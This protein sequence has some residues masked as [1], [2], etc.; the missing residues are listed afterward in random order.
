MIGSR[1]TSHGRLKI[2]GRFRNSIPSGTS[3]QSRGQ[4]ADIMTS[5]ALEMTSNGSSSV[6]SQPAQSSSSKIKVNA[7]PEP[8]L[9]SRKEIDVLYEILD[10][11]RKA[12]DLLN[13]D[14]IVTGGSLLGA[15]RQH[16]ILF[17]DDDI[18]IAILDPNYGT[19]ESV[20]ET[21]ILPNLQSA[22]NQV[23]ES[24]TASNESK[25][26]YVYQ[27]KP[28]EGGDRI[29][30]KR[31]NNVFLDLFVLR[32]Y[33]TLESFVSVIGT[34]KNGQAQPESYVNG[35]LE[36]IQT[37]V[38]KTRPGDAPKEDSVFPF[39]QFATRK[40]IELWPK[41]V[42]LS[43]SSTTTSENKHDELFPLQRNLKFGPLTGICGPQTPVTLLKRAFGDDCFEVYYRSISH[44]QQPKQ[45]QPDNNKNKTLPPKVAPG[46]TWNTSPKVALEEEH[47]LP[48]QPLAR[49]R[50]RPTFHCKSKLM[51]Y[52]E[53]ETIREQ[54]LR[55]ELTKIR[56]G[57]PKTY[58][59]NIRPRR[60]VYMDGVFDLFHIGHLEA[61]RQCAALG[62]R[63]IL[64]VTGDSDAEG[65]KR[66][67][68]VPESERTAIVGALEEVNEVVCPCPLVVTQEFMEKHQIDLVVHGF[69][70]DADAEK[71][72]EFFAI[73]MEL[74]KFQRI[75]YYRGLSTTDRIQNIRDQNHKEECQ[76]A[77]KTENQNDHAHKDTFESE[78]NQIAKPQ[79]F[80]A[81]LA[82][83]SNYASSIST[84]PF[85]LE[86]RL[87]IESHIEKARIRRREAL[88]AIRTATGS[89]VYD[90]IMK[91]FQIQQE[92]CN[93]INSQCVETKMEQEAHDKLVATLLDSVGFPP[94]TMLANLHN[95][96]LVED[97]S[98][99]D[100][101][102]QSLT[103]NYS[104]FQESYDSFVRKICVPKIAQALEDG[105]DEESCTKV[106]YQAFPCLRI[107]QPGEF[108][109]GPHSDVAY[110]HH[111]CSINGYVS[112]TQPDA[113]NHN[114][115]A[116][117][118]SLFLESRPGAE[119][120]HSL[121][122]RNNSGKCHTRFF[123]GALNLHWTTENLT[124]DTRVTFDFR[125]IDGRVFDKLKDGGHL[126]G[127]QKDV[128]RETPGYYQV[129]HKSETGEWI[130][131]SPVLQRPDFRVGFPW[132]V[133][134][135]DKFWKKQ[136]KPR[137]NAKD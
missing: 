73:P 71:Q 77:T 87:A 85:P 25:P 134:N 114:G 118:S 101:L 4:H 84:D 6:T 33:P 35:I 91:M 32:K 121:F 107:V 95:E 48:M 94:S 104:S 64:G 8:L 83:A 24:Q 49:K 68:I 135:W 115:L 98:A 123:P 15:I 53:T 109:I 128:F 17:C 44:Q 103:E 61:I 78:N 65:Y 126:E 88:Q 130:R 13:V 76:N 102:L 7:G 34:K 2:E 10:V 26:T 132:T 117:V 89:C 90:S 43:S 56:K 45:Q 18:D 92:R 29:R 14:Y 16:S 31:F 124:K 19:P 82:A 97:K 105:N 42:Y 116:P 137:T 112:L 80:G 63:V 37:C 129:C 46:G 122:G 96:P 60:T 133:K 38:A 57:I 106:Y 5:I 72:R 110:G 41:E 131:D 12:L 119:D 27:I 23:V 93:L 120:W 127:G 51:E 70:N 75:G 40:A 52:L 30:S 67:P 74:G 136:A 11:V 99:K 62:D 9:L 21:K 22:L 50:R 55:S 47:Y 36:T 69:A 54:V 20:Y 28:W 3:I 39:W 59:E 108:S 125:M 58:N 81:S 111:P 86:L 100:R 79:W 113:G 66:R 1:T